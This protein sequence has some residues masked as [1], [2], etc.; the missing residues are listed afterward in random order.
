[1]TVT[2][3]FLR[4]E[5]AVLAA[6]SVRANESYVELAR[7]G[8]RVRVLITGE[9]PAVL[10]LPGLGAVAGFWAP[11]LGNL[12]GQR[13]ITIERPGCGLSDPFD[14]R[15][16]DL[17]TWMVGLVDELLDAL[18]LPKVSLIGNSIGGTS[19]LWYALAHRDRVARIVLIGAPPFV[20]DA[21]A[22]LPMRILSIPA[23]GRKAVASTDEARIDAVFQRMGHRAGSLSPEMMELVKAARMLPTYGGGYVGVLHAATGLLGRRVSAPAAELSTIEQPTLMIWGRNDSHGPVSNGRRMAEVMPDARLEVCG[24]GHLPWIDEPQ[25]CGELI[26]EFLRQESRAGAAPAVKSDSRP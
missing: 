9:G 25:R 24:E 17:R 15:G 13:L 7:S 10:L 19:S 26:G 16:D 6:Y 4:A 2:D 1:M 22:P 20:L 12:A 11:L 18:E 21:Q 23:I 3:H 14:L 5:N 8:R